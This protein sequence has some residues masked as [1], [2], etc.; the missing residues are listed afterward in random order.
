[1][2]E[3]PV[4]RSAFQTI[5]DLEPQ[6]IKDLITLTQIPSPPF[7]EKLRAKNLADASRDW[8][9]SI[10]TDAAGNVIALRNAA[11]QEKKR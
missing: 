8:V 9:D 5:L 1:L 4:I 6:T 7:K 11:N 3:Q 10:W 2:A